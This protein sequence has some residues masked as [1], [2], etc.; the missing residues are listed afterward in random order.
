MESFVSPTVQLIQ[1]SIRDT[2]SNS[3]LKRITHLDH[4]ALT[5]VINS[6]LLKCKGHF[7]CR[8]TELD[9]ANQSSCLSRLVFC[10][11]ALPCFIRRNK[12]QSHCNEFIAQCITQKKILI[13]HIRNHFLTINKDK[14]YLSSFMTEHQSTFANIQLTSLNISSRCHIHSAYWEHIQV[15]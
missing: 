11:Q 12:K 3:D 6:Q 7:Y 9:R 8:N 4:F 5:A 15:L 13:L 2:W 10:L 14:R 1:L